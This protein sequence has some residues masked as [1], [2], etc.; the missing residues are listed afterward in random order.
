MKQLPRYGLMFLAGLPLLLY[1]SLGLVYM[2]QKKGQTDAFAQVQ[3]SL[4]LLR[5]PVPDM[6]G[7]Q[8][9]IDQLDAAIAQEKDLF[10]QQGSDALVAGLLQ[11]AQAAGLQVSAVSARPVSVHKD[12][13]GS[14]SVLPITVQA[15]GSEPQLMGFLNSL[16]Y[17]NLEVQNVSL[18]ETKDGYAFNLELDFHIT[19]KE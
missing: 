13:D 17:P 16:D 4:E 14:Y 2:Q 19:A 7:I 12:D 3:S 15:V 11:K 1:M 8:D 5:R 9:Q 6:N 10:S 18:S